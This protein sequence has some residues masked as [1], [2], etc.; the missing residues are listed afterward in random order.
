QAL[1]RILLD[2]SFRTSSYT[3][4]KIHEPKERTVFRLPYYPDR[5]LHH[6]IMLHLKPLFNSWFT[7]D[8]YSCIEGK[9]VHKASDNLMKALKDVP[10]ATYCLKLDISKFYPSVDHETLKAQLR[11]KIKDRELIGLLD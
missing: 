11:R 2:K 7:N 1:H 9:G 5:I 10:N 6:A 3:T 4:F 8:S